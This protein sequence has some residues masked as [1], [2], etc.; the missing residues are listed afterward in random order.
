MLSRNWT[1]ERRGRRAPQGEAIF[2]TAIPVIR[3]ALSPSFSPQEEVR[4][5]SKIIFVFLCVL[6]VALPQ[7]LVC[8]TR[9]DELIESFTLESEQTLKDWFEPRRH[10]GHRGGTEK[11]SALFSVH[12][13]HAA[14]IRLTESHRATNL[15]P[16]STRKLNHRG[17]EDTEDARRKVLIL[18]L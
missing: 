17:T 2:E 18:S 8:P 12:P 4:V 9:F 7:N 3:I 13:L 6:C 11:G 1:G 10:R 16:S 5:S 15:H 14:T